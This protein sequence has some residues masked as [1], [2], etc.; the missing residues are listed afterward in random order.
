MRRDTPDK[1]TLKLIQKG[2]QSECDPFWLAKL[3]AGALWI[4]GASAP[5]PQEPLAK[6]AVDAHSGLQMAVP[7]DVLRHLWFR[8][9]DIFAPAHAMV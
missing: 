4:S 1:R 5:A 3:R 8:G 7:L 6:P 2:N 9:P